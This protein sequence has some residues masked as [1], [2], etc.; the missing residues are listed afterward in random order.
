M[1]STPIL[2]KPAMASAT[3]ADIK[4]H[5]RR[6]AKLPTGW[7]IPPAKVEGGFLNR[8]GNHSEERIACPYGGPGSTLWLREEHY[9]FGHWEPVKG[10]ETKGGRQK[11][12]FVA[13]RADCIFAPPT[14]EYGEPTPYRVSRDVNDPSKPQWY[15]RLARF[16][17]RA[18][19]RITL[20]IVEVRIER[21]NDISELNAWKEGITASAELASKQFSLQTLAGLCMQFPDTNLGSLAA[22]DMRLFHFGDDRK[23]PSDYEKVVATTGRGCFAYLWESINGPGSWVKSPFVWVIVFR[24]I[25]N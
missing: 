9:R 2:M 8:Y 4:T 6:I 13:D 1:K 16:M 20:E 10:V 14:A 12:R 25:K 22:D 23:T 21:L 24:R 17:P 15:K 18:L 5:T 7:S 11:W 19:S 3:M